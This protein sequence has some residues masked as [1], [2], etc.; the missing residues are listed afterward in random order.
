MGQ[1]SEKVS[2]GDPRVWR[3]RPTH[4]AQLVALNLLPLNVQLDVIVAQ[5]VRLRVERH[6]LDQLEEGARVHNGDPG[7]AVEQR[8][9]GGRQCGDTA[10][11][12]RLQ[13]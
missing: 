5:D 9:E 10:N 4:A 2:G 3:R 11:Y 13:Q 6:V 8:R 1:Q 12:D 7:K